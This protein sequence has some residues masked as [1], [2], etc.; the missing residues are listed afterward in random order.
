LTVLW[1][2][3]TVATFIVA[4]TISLDGQGFKITEQTQVGLW[5]AAGLAVGWLLGG[6]Q[7]HP[8]RILG[9]VP[10]GVTGMF[11]GLLLVALGVPL[12]HWLYLVLGAM[13]EWTSLSIPASYPV[14]KAA[15]GRAVRAHL[16]NFLVLAALA[17]A[18]TCVVVIAL[19]HGAPRREA[20]MLWTLVAAAA[21]V[22]VVAWRVF[23]REQMELILEVLLLPFYRIR[24]RGPGLE[25]MPPR[26]PVL[27]V[28]NHSAWLDPMWLAKVLPR[29]MI[30]M[31]TSVF[32]DLPIMR[33]LMEHVAHAIRVQASTFRRE[34]PE[35]DV[36]IAA[37]DRGEL[38][39]IFPEGMMRRR[40]NVPLR[41]FGQGVWH[42]LSERP[43]T[44]VI[45][46]WIDGG[47]G[48]Y[49]S[50]FNGKPTR[51]K[52]MDFWRSIDIAV[53]PCRMLDPELLKDLRQTRS[54]LMEEC[55]QTRRF[56]GLPALALKTAS[57]EENAGKVAAEDVG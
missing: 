36:A 47:W 7:R 24:A 31:M 38:V 44:P 15:D 55:L 56:L 45:V 9:L 37:L 2:A 46:C 41:Q 35:L 18:M 54:F 26:G 23:F 34:A 40:E 6:L 29:R 1:L 25:Q 39:V 21:L 33:W 4:L 49:F 30:P 19:V 50:Y 14:S 52:R 57:T 22:A 43:A 11:L 8:R 48:S 20:W 13:W 53:G 51:N 12:A 42:I 10:F 3:Q 27:V 28:A 32:Y 16:R 17:M 5:F